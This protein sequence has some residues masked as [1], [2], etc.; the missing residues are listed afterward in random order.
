MDADWYVDPQGQYDG[1]YFDGEA[2]TNQVSAGGDFVIDPDWTPD[3]NPVPDEPEPPAPPPAPEVA[4]VEVAAPG[5]A[6][7]TAP[8]VT[9][10]EV[11]AP[12]VA[13]PEL[14]APEVTAPEVTAP[15]LTVPEVTVPEVTAPE[16]TAPEVEVAAP[17][18]RDVPE[19]EVVAPG[20]PEVAAPIARE[21]PE[22]ELPAPAARDAESPGA[23]ASA[24]FDDSGGDVPAVAPLTGPETRRADLTH[25]S[26]ARTVAVLDEAK[27]SPS[28]TSQARTSFDEPR[29]RHWPALLLLALVAASL[30]VGLIWFLDRD[31]NSASP[32]A[33]S[34]VDLPEGV[35]EEG[36]TFDPS[37][38]IEVGELRVV[39]GTSLLDDL[40]SWHVDFAGSRGVELTASASCW[41]G[42][43]GDAAVQMAFC[44]PVGVDADENL[45]DKVPLIFANADDADLGLV[46]QPVVD[47]VA[48]DSRLARSLE[49]VGV[50]DAPEG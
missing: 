9:A 46:A 26:P 13:A 18:E 8:E 22:V 10:P 1:R 47:A 48:I 19:V 16:V 2:W 41:L 5:T 14:T 50:V 37:E 30:V 49:L 21:V 23:I 27:P 6:Q 17:I 34:E 42:R 3:P 35:V 43:L 24:E 29:R 11:A 4:D 39:N 33:T 32:A 7:V 36:A 31:S 12:E 44:G 45:Y 28:P 40:S 20:T 38:T 25:E 15:E